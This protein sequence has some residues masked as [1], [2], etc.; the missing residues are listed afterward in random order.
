MY[1]MNGKSDSRSFVV[2][3]TLNGW[4]HNRRL[5]QYS[6]LHLCDKRLNALSYY[7]FEAN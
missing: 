3:I 4:R 1:C 6:N 2:N 7:A 5:Q